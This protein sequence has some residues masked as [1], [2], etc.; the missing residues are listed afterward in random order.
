L[1]AFP[2][3]L[4]CFFWIVELVLCLSAS[5]VLHHAA[6]RAAR[7]AAVVL[8]DNPQFY[9]GE[10]T[11]QPSGRRRQDVDLAAALVLKNA[12][13]VENMKLT[14]PSTPDGDDDRTSV[15][16][17]DLVHVRLKAEYRCFLPISRGI[18][19][20]VSSGTRSLETVAS[21]LTQGATYDEL[22]PP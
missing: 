1:V 6:V 5:L 15:K 9:D 22:K 17:T 7:A 16:P 18:V 3:V 10:P 19:C 14:L 20:D 21:F 8:F 13:H 4:F 12:P 11:G 2:I